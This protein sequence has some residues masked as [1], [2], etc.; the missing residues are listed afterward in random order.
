[1]RLLSILILMVSVTLSTN[2]MVR[3]RALETRVAEM[4][5][6]RQEISQ[7]SHQ[8]VQEARERVQELKQDLDLRQGELN[9]SL[10]EKEA[11][12]ADLDKTRAELKSVEDNYEL[13][14][15]SVSGV[16]GQWLDMM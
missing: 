4:E 11:F 1:M 9:K 16:S 13:L 3:K 15:D 12:T 14:L 6:F 10:A 5:Q 2:F 8:H 7:E